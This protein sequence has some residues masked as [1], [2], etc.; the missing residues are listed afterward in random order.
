MQNSHDE[1]KIV[2]AQRITTNKVEDPQR[3]RLTKGHCVLLVYY[4]RLHF[5]DRF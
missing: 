2:S 3:E 1:V 5:G 4:R